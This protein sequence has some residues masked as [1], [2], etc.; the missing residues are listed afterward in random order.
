MWKVPRAVGL[1]VLTAGT[2]NA[3]P[4]ELGDAHFLLVHG[5][6]RADLFRRAALPGPNGAIVGTDT[7]LPIR[8]TVLV[9]A[10]DL[11][12]PLGTDSADVE[13]SGW[14]LVAFPE[15]VP[16]QSP[17]GDVQTAYVRLRRGPASF[18]LGRQLVTGGAARYARFDGLALDA[19]LGQGFEASAYGGLTAL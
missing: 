13:A 15:G 16:M 8:E 9:R 5:E 6:T 7:L 3:G 4:S 19:A 10:E 2:V 18:R 1:V 17:D 12:T 14:A 11:D